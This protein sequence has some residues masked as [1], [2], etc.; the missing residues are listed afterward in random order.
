[1]KNNSRKTALL[2]RTSGKLTLTTESI[3]LDFPKE[4]E[5][6]TS[7]EYTFRVAAPENAESVELSVNQ[8]PWQSCR[9]SSG[10]WW[11]DWIGFGSGSYQTR[12]RMRTCEGRVMTTLARRFSV[13]N[14][15]NN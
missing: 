10:Y 7:A 15:R 2:D 14:S 13:E 1:M 3:A 6:L 4:G 5:R 8:G 12:A 9:L 11:Y